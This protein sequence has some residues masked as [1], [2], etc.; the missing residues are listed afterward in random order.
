MTTFENE[1]QYEVVET[2]EYYGYKIEVSK[3]DCV[4]IYIAVV[5][6]DDGSMNASLT[7]VSNEDECK[8]ALIEKCEQRILEVI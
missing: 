1:Y 8:E 4:E 6:N 2:I 7:P 5:L 3:N